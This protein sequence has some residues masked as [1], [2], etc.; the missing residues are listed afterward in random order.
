MT[1]VIRKLRKRLRSKKT[2]RTWQGQVAQPDDAVGLQA[3]GASAP[4]DRSGITASEQELSRPCRRRSPNEPRA[5][6]C[7]LREAADLVVT[8]RTRKRRKVED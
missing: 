2:L 6:D 8:R 1:V 5:A 3:E 4:T 7:A